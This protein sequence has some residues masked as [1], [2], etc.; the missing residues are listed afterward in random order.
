MKSLDKRAEL[1]KEAFR[2]PVYDEAGRPFITQKIELNVSSDEH[3]AGSHKPEDKDI[4]GA[5]LPDDVQALLKRFTQHRIDYE[6]TDR[7]SYPS[8]SNYPQ[9]RQMFKQLRN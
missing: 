5:N 2:H 9:L 7:T 4:L 1:L 3:A 8:D 6:W